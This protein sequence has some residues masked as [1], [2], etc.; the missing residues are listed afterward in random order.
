MGQG[1]AD[2][3]ACRNP[4]AKRLIAEVSNRPVES[5]MDVAAQFIADA[6]VSPEGRAGVE[7]FL[8]RNNPPW[9]SR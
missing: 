9:V 4:A 7:A 2:L 6:R 5:V 3:I 8:S 1:T